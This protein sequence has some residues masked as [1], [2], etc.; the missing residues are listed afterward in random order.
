MR[1]DADRFAE[2][3][4]PSFIIDYAGRTNSIAAAMP[5]G[6]APTPF[7]PI[8]AF[9]TGVLAPSATALPYPSTTAV[10]QLGVAG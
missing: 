3:R 9:L 7:D 1:A 8:I 2:Q 5:V 4:R 6:P 10:F